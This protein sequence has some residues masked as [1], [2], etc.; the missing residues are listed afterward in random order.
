M[1][2]V[3]ATVG[4]LIDSEKIAYISSIDS[5][6]Y[7][8][9]KALFTP[10]HRIGI[11]TLYFTITETSHM[12]QQ[13]QTDSKACVYFFNK[14][15]MRGIMLRGEMEVLKGDKMIKLDQE[16]NEGEC[17]LRF[18]AHCGRFYSHFKSE[19]FEIK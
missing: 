14:R 5:E 2:N 13:Y 12:I 10:V 11:K 18:T 17:M 1:R 19:K 3:E 7:P 4:N 16:L 9:T 8:N 6:G 15:F